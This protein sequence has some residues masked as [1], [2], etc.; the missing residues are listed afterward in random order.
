MSDGSSTLE[1]TQVVD[2]LIEA[3]NA[4]DADAFANLFAEDA[5]AY[6]HPG[7]PAQ[8]G[9]ESIR[10]FYKAGFAAHPENR[11]VVLHR[12]VIGNYVIDHEQVRRSPAHEPFETLAI[13]EVRDGLV[14]RLDLVRK[15]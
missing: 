3:Y 4:S 10:A 12:I 5:V 7:V 9:R 13:N 1:N 14:R 6:E 15:H 11:T 8:V 2:A